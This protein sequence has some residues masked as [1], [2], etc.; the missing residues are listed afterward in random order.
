MPIISNFKITNFADYARFSGID[1]FFAEQY[2]EQGMKYLETFCTDN[3]DEL[4]KRVANLGGK[5]ELSII[6]G[7]VLWCLIK[8]AYDDGRNFYKGMFV[9]DSG[10]DKFAKYFYNFLADFSY[11]RLTSHYYREATHLGFDYVDPSIPWPW[12][13]KTVVFGLMHDKKGGYRVFF[14]PERFS[15]NVFKKTRESIRHGFAFR[16][17]KFKWNK[18]KPF[19][20]TTLRETDKNPDKMPWQRGKELHVTMR[21][22][23]VA[24]RTEAAQKR[25]NKIP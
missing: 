4:E 8:M 12:Q 13:F 2:A 18:W 6:I 20:T 24:L 10:E 16:D 21:K 5:E 15:F 7:C 25:K 23:G 11:G 1:P 9:L 3:E 22:D 14:K 17:F 19:G